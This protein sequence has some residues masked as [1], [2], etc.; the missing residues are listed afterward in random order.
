MEE[1]CFP[2]PMLWLVISSASLN[3]FSETFYDN[4]PAVRAK[5][6]GR[7]KKTISCKK[8]TELPG[9]SSVVI[10]QKNINQ[11]DRIRPL[12]ELVL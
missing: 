2:A 12:L 6:V 4:F 11:R 8:V 10:G 1:Y 9:W 5:Q 7:I 3:L